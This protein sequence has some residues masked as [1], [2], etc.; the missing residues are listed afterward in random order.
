[1]SFVKEA[2][3]CYRYSD[4][5]G[6]GLALKAEIELQGACTNA[7]M[8]AEASGAPGAGGC[9]QCC[10]CTSGGPAALSGVH[11]WDRGVGE[12]LC[13]SFRLTGD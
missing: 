10:R 1:M 2:L 9:P 8:E 7:P 13:G 11:S 3:P 5:S 6:A 12:R 4:P